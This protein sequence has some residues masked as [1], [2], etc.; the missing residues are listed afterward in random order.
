M[1]WIIFLIV[2]LVSV[3]LYWVLIHFI[4]KDKCINN[5][6]KIP[7]LFVNFM[8]LANS[9]ICILII[10]VIVVRLI[11]EIIIYLLFNNK[12]FNKFYK[13]K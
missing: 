4:I 2:Y 6:Y 13:L 8:P 12:S 1:E 9:F 5:D 10:Y 7:I 3:V 11:F